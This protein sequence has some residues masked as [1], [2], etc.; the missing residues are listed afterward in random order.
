MPATSVGCDHGQTDSLIAVALEQASKD[1]S[2]ALADAR[3]ALA[4]VLPCND[5]VR[6]RQAYCAQAHAWRHAGQIDSALVYTEKRLEAARQVGDQRYIAAAYNE[7]G[8]LYVRLPNLELAEHYY[9]E[10]AKLYE[11]IGDSHGVAQVHNNLGKLARRYPDD[12]IH[13]ARQWHLSAIRHFTASGVSPANAW[14]SL[15]NYYAT[16][17]SSWQAERAYGMA[18]QT[19]RDSADEYNEAKLYSSRSKFFLLN[20]RL[21][22]AER[23]LKACMA[24]YTK[25]DAKRSE[26]IARRSLGNL[27]E[28]RGDRAS[29]RREYDYAFALA[30]EVMDGELTTELSNT[31]AQMADEQ[32]REA[33]E[34]RERA[35]RE[36]RRVTVVS[37]ALGFL[38][39]LVALLSF[40]NLRYQR[41]KRKLDMALAEAR[42]REERQ[43]LLDQI[44]TREVQALEANFKGQQL[45]RQ[46]IARNLHDQLGG[47]LS[48]LKLYYGSVEK[49]IEAPGDKLE[50]D[51]RRLEELIDLACDEVRRVSHDL[52]QDQ[53]GPRGLE[54]ALG[55]MAR[56]LREAGGYTVELN[57]RL[58]GREL[59]GAMTRHL[60]NVVQELVTNTIKYARAERIGIQVLARDGML[61]LTYEDDGRGFDSARPTEGIGLRNMRER[62]EELGG[63]LHL[64]AVTGRGTSVVIDLPLTLTP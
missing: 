20:E 8:N 54:A 38:L 22:E 27:Y 47:L 34:E 11:R 53:L 16:V 39:A 57:V 32:K 55:A 49:R 2:R 17:D 26:A 25:L 9:G 63:E 44:K 36:K 4:L 41:K 59:A 21:E 10:A 35:E 28:A 50:K 18:L 30:N 56:T 42:A 29:A 7:L 48:S 58:Q 51:L 45:E 64:D 6:M 5:L 31:L 19:Y 33:E 52:K 23:D 3:R 46:R 43:G 15:G 12:R 37:L 24:I 13:G 62:V 40:L 60:I 61:N 1:N 14:F